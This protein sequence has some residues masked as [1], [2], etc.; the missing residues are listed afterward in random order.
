MK[1]LF[2]LPFVL[3]AMYVFTGCSDNDDPK[4]LTHQLSLASHTA[5]TDYMGDTE[6][7]YD[8]WTDDWGYSYKLTALTDESGVFNFNCVIGDW[9]YYGGYM[10]TNKTSGNYSAITKKGVN[11]S[12]YITAGP[13]EKPAVYLNFMDSENKTKT[14][15]Y[16]VN[17][18]Y[19]TNSYYAC[20]SMQNGDGMAKKFEAGDWFML[21][22]QNADK[23]KKVEAYLADFRDG[24][25]EIVNT[26][27]WVDLKALGE[28]SGLHFKLTST[29]NGDYGM[30]TPNY[31]CLDGITITEKGK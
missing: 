31:F 14:K 22:I 29:D 7:P 12:T 24:K 23:S 30:N 4:D 20:N 13:Q 21:T 8:T 10:V 3:L 28:T 1:K 11:G 9:G 26:W 27:K 16:S 19:I 6:N 5:E 2:L 15:A 18:L 25:T 17:G